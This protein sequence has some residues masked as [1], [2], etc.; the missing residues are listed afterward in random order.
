MTAIDRLARLV[1]EAPKIDQAEA[2]VRSRNALSDTIA[3]LYAGANRPVTTNAL[4]AVKSWG[5]GDSIVVGHSM[6][7]SPPFAAMV[8]GA[9]AHAL[10]YDDYDGPANAH[11]SAVIFPALLALAA[12]RTVSG[13]DLLDAYIVGVEVLQR[14]G[15]AMNMDHYRRGW[16]STLTLGTIAAAA[17]CARLGNYDHRTCVSSLSLGVSMASG[18]INQVGFLAKQLHPGLAAKNGVM[19]SALASAG[20]SASDETIDGP[21]GLA[22]LMG[23]YQSQKFEAALAKLGSPWSIIEHGLLMKAYPTCGYTHR[24]IDAAIDIH[25]QLPGDTDNIRSIRISVPDYYLDILKYPSPQST[26]EAM[27][28]AQYNVAAALA[29]GG[30]SL[31]ELSTEVI[32]DEQLQRL[33][34]VSTLIAR[35]PRDSDIVYDVLDPDVVE[36]ALDDGTLLRSEVCLPTGAP[37]KPMSE[38]VRRAK[39]DDCLIQHKGESARD[40]LWNVLDSIESLDECSLLL[41]KLTN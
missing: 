7:L 27:F 33:C 14:L 9:S 3:C 23:D 4:E 31:T 19:A 38:A 6:T 37:N 13:L 21:I 40:E 5:N 15:E 11:P 29:R 25:R 12:E 16:L 30:F 18:F 32:L 24:L 1:A 34:E 10:D 20:I 41:Q 36:V 22:K 39:F 2:I 28:S 17:A 8:N 35:S 26:T